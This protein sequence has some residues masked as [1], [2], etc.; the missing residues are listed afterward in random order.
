MERLFI[1]AFGTVPAK[2]VVVRILVA[3]STGG[4]GHA[5]KFGKRF[6]I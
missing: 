2:L 1:V 6:A 3:V 4:E 5:R